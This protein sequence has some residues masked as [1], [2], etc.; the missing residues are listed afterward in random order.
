MTH[1]LTNQDLRERFQYRPPEN[2]VEVDAR[3]HIRERYL[4]LATV[5]NETLQ[6]G[7][8][9][10]EVLVALERSCLYALQALMTQG[11]RKP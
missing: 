5:L 1:R 10:Y 11:V 6:E 8:Y 2:Q 3:R 4:A 7:E 9:K